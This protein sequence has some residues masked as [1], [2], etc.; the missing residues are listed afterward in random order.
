MCAIEQTLLYGSET[1]EPNASARINVA[2][3]FRFLRNA[4]SEIL[5]VTKSRNWVRKVSISGGWRRA[6]LEMGVS[7][8]RH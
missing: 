4:R 7:M 5:S 3:T 2:Y 8:Q 6:E 1:S